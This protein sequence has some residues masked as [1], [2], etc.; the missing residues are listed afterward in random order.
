M[1]RAVISSAIRASRSAN[2]R[3]TSLWRSLKSGSHHC[4]MNSTTGPSV[5][6]ATRAPGCDASATAAGGSARVADPLCSAVYGLVGDGA[7]LPVS[8]PC[9]RGV[10]A[11]GLPRGPGEAGL[12]CPSAEAAGGVKR[13]PSGP[14]AASCE[15]VLLT[16][17]D[18]RSQSCAGP[19]PADARSIGSAAYVPGMDKE[20]ALEQIDAAVAVA[21]RALKESGDYGE[22]ATLCASTIARLTDQK[23]VYAAQSKRTLDRRDVGVGFYP[24]QLAGVLKALQADIEA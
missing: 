18:V 22:A 3:G 19:L 23:S 15:A 13:S 21:E 8:I 12:P 10:H 5:A 16:P 2:G 11:A 24:L 7:V 6:R 4:S 1:L 20:R 14:S 9:V 17:A